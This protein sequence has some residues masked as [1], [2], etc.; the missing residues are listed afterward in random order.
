MTMTS[1]SEQGTYKNGKPLTH[2][3]IE[4]VE[5]IKRKARARKIL[6]ARDL[7]KRMRVLPDGS[8]EFLRFSRS[9]RLEH[10][11]LL[12]SFTILAV[13]G[14]A[15]RYSQSRLVGDLINLLGGVETVR[16]LHRL[17]AL[18]LAV[19]AAYH[20]FT[21]LM[22]WF[23][24]RERGSMWPHVRDFADL[25]QMVKYNIGLATKRPEFDRFGIEEKI[26]Y[27]ALLWGCLLMGLTG[28]IQ[29]FPV[30]VTRFL[31]GELIPISRAVHSW[32]A[33]LAVLAILIWHGYHAVLKE[34]NMSIFTGIM[35][36]DEMQEMH[37]VEYRRI[38]AAH[39]YLEK[40]A[41]ENGGS[42]GKG[43]AGPLRSRAV[44]VPAGHSETA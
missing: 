2:E 30:Q 22:I 44:R 29:W 23:V 42:N 34:R 40:I 12:V 38:L 15:Q 35:S 3:E 13:T 28:F 43:Q 5:K 8:R 25:F 9:Q 1:N 36:E 21:I 33:V 11:V 27:W 18:V 16:T 26:E 24:K 37:P 17:S 39:E 4:L 31:P 14:L 41:L 6:S 7:A 20:L 32:E 19:L 10:Q